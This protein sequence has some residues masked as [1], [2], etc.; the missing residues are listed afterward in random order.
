MTWIIS[1]PYLDTILVIISLRWSR[2]MMSQFKIR[3]VTSFIEIV[4]ILGFFYFALDLSIFL[5]FIFYFRDP[6]TK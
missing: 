5:F 6:K 4:L 3:F 2:S 1:M